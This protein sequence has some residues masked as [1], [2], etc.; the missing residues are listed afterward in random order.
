M[1]ELEYT[2][3]AEKPKLGRA[4][5][6]ELA[7][8]SPVIER[9]EN[10]MKGRD[11]AVCWARGHIYELEEPEYYIKRAHPNL[12]LGAN[13]KPRWDRAHLPVLPGPTEFKLRPT[14]RQFLP[15]IR[16]LLGACR[17]VVHAGDPDREGQLVVDEIL[18]EMGNRKPVKRFLSSGLDEI[19]VRAG[20]AA[21]RDNS[22]F[23]RQ[24]S[25]AR[26][27]SRADWVVGMNM[28]RGL[29]LRAQDCGFKGFI[30]F[31]RVQT[32]VLSLIAMR[33]RE[34]QAFRPTDYFAL[35]ASIGV[36][37][38]QFTA[39]WQPSASQAGLDADGRLLDH[40][41]ARVLQQKVAGQTGTIAAYEDVEK[42]QKAPL[43]FSLAQL[44]MRASKRFGY[45]SEET[46]KAV[47]SLYDQ[48]FVSYPRTGSQ[49]LPSGL[50][51]HAPAT[52]AI[53]QKALGLSQDVIAQVNPRMKSHAWNDGKVKG[54][55]GLVPLTKEPELSALS[56]M[57]RD[58]YQEI[59]RRYVA[60]FLPER[61]LRSVTAT[62]EVA[63]EYFKATGSTTIVPGWK[64]LY[65]DEREPGEENSILPAMKKGEP[66]KCSG[67]DIAA[68]KTEPPKRF[69]D[70]SLTYAML[71]V[72]EYVSDPRLKEVFKRMR[73][74][75]ST[76]EDV[77]G[78][79]TPATRHTFVPKLE[80]SGLVTV[81]KPVGKSKEN[82]YHPTATAMALVDALPPDLGRP[83]TTAMWESVFEKIEQGGTTENDFLKVLGNWVGKRLGDLDVA[84][85]ELPP[86]DRPQGKVTSSRGGSRSGG[87]TSSGVGASRP[88]HRA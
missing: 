70:S 29:T 84:Q 56:R 48:K 86:L 23:A 44:Q 62:A 76:D 74:D 49:H 9:G 71:H 75:K 36:A 16:K 79:G 80:S 73:L 51:E 37:G 87:R 57:E 32:A 72:E 17:T 21:M 30:P 15:A 12:V 27:R 40:N 2:F 59:C 78:I 6:E 1:A 50:L 19:S 63:G 68:K 41:I 38:G 11:W 33:E 34:I 55:H 18:E 14:E 47:Q 4:I 10:F 22:E 67:L 61:T 28:T 8:R 42:Q 65:G 46:L 85:L 54:H 24:S 26:A 43:P 83:D 20:L 81:Q 58:I 60:Q 31:G 66:A 82:T 69:T 88:S 5:A 45:K 25:A 35:T 53:A 77:G 7:I 52:L 64:A 3:V 13:G 39:K